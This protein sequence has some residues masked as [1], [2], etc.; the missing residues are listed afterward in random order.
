MARINGEE[1]RLSS[2]FSDVLTL[3]GNVRLS[4]ARHSWS[5]PVVA[6]MYWFAIGW[7]SNRNKL[8]RMIA[9]AWRWNDV[10]RRW[11]NITVTGN[12]MGGW[13]CHSSIGK[14]CASF[15]IGPVRIRWCFADNRG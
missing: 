14:R 12:S 11:F 4:Y 6:T 8:C 15:L 2:I 5:W 1:I 9:I 10:E 13:P 3:E 7:G